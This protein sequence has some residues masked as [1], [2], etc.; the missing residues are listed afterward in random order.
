MTPCGAP[1]FSLGVLWFPMSHSTSPAPSLIAAGETLGV[2]GAG[3]RGRTL[4][5]GLFDSGAISREQAWASA[6]S[7]STCDIASHELGIPVAT[8][9]RSRVPESGLILVCVKPKQAAVV[10]ATLRS[11]G[12]RPE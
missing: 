5:H 7:Q 10:A 8:D 4:L 1:D 9:W 6:K 11:A 3:V 2:I 12:L